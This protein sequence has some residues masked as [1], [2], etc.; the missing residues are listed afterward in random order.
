MNAP[1][2]QVR[3]PLL[4]GRHKVAGLWLPAD[5]LGAE[6]RTALL[7]H[8]WH[9]DA[10]AWR[11]ADGDLL[12]FASARP[13]DC[14]GL[15]GWPLLALKNG[16][17]CSAELTAEERAT[18]PA[19]DLWL[20]R[21]G[22]VQALRLADARR[23]ALEEHIALDG[24]PLLDTYDCRAILPPPMLEVLPPI[25]D[26]HAILDGKVKPPSPERDAFLKSLLQQQ[27]A[28]GQGTASK[29]TPRKA[30]S[31][32]AS[33]KSGISA[34]WAFW[35]SLFAI[36]M[37]GNFIRDAM[38][39]PTNLPPPTLSATPIVEAPSDGSD[40]V[41]IVILITL[42]VLIAM[43]FFAALRRFFK[44]DPQGWTAQ[45][46]APA[47]GSAQV[48]AKAPA[49]PPIKSRATQAPHGPSAWRRLLTSLAITSKFSELLNRRQSAYMR[50]MLKMFEEGDIAEALRHALPLGGE[51]GNLGQ[52]FGT[53]TRR[54]D[55]DLG[56]RT[57][58]GT[59]ISL[60]EDLEAH[61]RTLYR[62][63]FEKLDREGRID[64]AVFIL[65]ELLKARQEALDYLERHLRFRQAADLALAWDMPAD[66]IV[67]LHCLAG[68]WR[69][70]LQV[71]RRDN[72]FA[73]AVEM[74]EKK[75]P[76]AAQRLRQD[77]AE[78]LVARGDWLEAVD[79]IWPLPDK[80]ALAA[81]WL[82][83]AEEAGGGLSAEA[84]VKRA[85]LL[86]DTLDAYAAR[87][88]SL[89]DDPTLAGER[90][91]LAQALNRVG[92]VPRA[93]SNEQLQRL[94][95]LVLPPLL[96][97]HAR[98][99]VNLSRRDLQ[100]LL[101]LSQ[102]K[103][104][105]ADLPPKG[106]PEQDASPLLQQNPPL[107]WQAPP[108]G[109]RAILDAAPL[110]EGRTLVALGEAGLAVLDDLGRT[111]FRFA[112][113]GH[114]I[115]LARNRRAALALARR[116]QVWRI[117]KLDLVSRKATDLGVLAMDFHAYEFDGTSWTI[118]NS[119]SVRVV[120]VD[121][122]F[123][124]VWHVSDLP[125][126]L[127]AFQGCAGF[128]QWLVEDGRGGTELW[129]YALPTRRLTHRYEVLP[130]RHEGGFYVPNPD[131]GLLEV[132]FRGNEAGEQSLLIHT[133]GGSREIALPDVSAD[134]VDK[135][136]L[137]L[138]NGWLL[139]GTATD[140]EMTHWRLVN[141][142]TLKTCAELEWP[143]DTP[144][145]SR[146]LEHDWRLFDCTGRLLRLD[147]LTSELRE[148]RS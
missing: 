19:A 34:S 105:Q 144:L 39:Q 77:W 10:S 68:D 94:A 48:P 134:Q 31:R 133:H 93:R 124:V 103:L 132:W 127:L 7:L 13:M 46:S 70:A 98:S 122:A 125:G 9:A 60:G 129:R 69:T 33:G 24:Y 108:A 62:Q 8:H 18:L 49:A 92:T 44:G 32:A 56:K 97:D 20:V 16:G 26:I 42:A 58:P 83:C 50:R 128:E 110:A 140:T 82:L 81:Q 1:D 80:Q 47:Q 76:Q 12:R 100:S 54:D 57:G 45:P 109:Q 121:R 66:S 145:Q 114:R 74:L 67:R 3:Q 131:G 146:S 78:M 126:H 59:A 115:V 137:K 106:L 117:T 64:E 96:E 118:G 43:L 112:E 28:A 101:N 17:L 27:A 139:L 142:R 141:P 123:A 38:R 61:L 84:L 116:D 120:D 135:T 79:V 113:P 72:A 107:Q 136:N 15:V 147:T 89:R 99:R 40:T 143:S 130:S 51:Q 88:K 29:P 35:L 91:A 11:F 41:L 25:K 30:P 52:A 87:L 119:R 73:N 102:D 55:L 2:A 4:K 36:M 37:V 138:A 148:L 6:E 86:P 21:G 71:A 14:D 95:R 85:V 63:H 104:L 111:L 22:R 53:P 65:A 75:W 90:L 23:L 5:W